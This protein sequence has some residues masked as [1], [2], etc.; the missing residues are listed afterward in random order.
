MININTIDSVE[1]FGGLLDI[2]MLATSLLL[3]VPI[4]GGAA[5]EDTEK[6]APPP[7]YMIMSGRYSGL[8]NLLE[9]TAGVIQ[10]SSNGQRRGGGPGGTTITLRISRSIMIIN[11]SSNIISINITRSSFWA[12]A[13]A[14][15]RSNPFR[16]NKKKKQMTCF[17]IRDCII[18]IQQNEFKIACLRIL[19]GTIIMIM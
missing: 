13:P 8:L 15:N 19:H 10:E 3:K 5:G 17:I 14:T 9:D 1:K 6:K 4:P 7:G 12:W 16:M 18:C 11:S 2:N